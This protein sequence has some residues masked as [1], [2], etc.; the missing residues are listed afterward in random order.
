MNLPRIQVI[1]GEGALWSWRLMTDG[2]TV[3]SHD[4]GYATEEDARRAAAAIA[5]RLI[6]E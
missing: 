4:E 3:L 1:Q 6:T 2:G 5:A